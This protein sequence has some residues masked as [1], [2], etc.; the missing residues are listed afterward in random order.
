MQELIW[1]LQNNQNF[2]A[3]RFHIVLKHRDCFNHVSNEFFF[4]NRL[5]LFSDGT[6]KNIKNFSLAIIVASVPTV[7]NL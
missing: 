6:T 5:M 4:D 2:V 3:D 1:E 7:K